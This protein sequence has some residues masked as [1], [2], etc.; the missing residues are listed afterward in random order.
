MVIPKCALYQLTTHYS[1]TIIEVSMSLLLFIQLQVI[2]YLIHQAV[3]YNSSAITQYFF[4]PLA[5]HA[6]QCLE[7]SAARR[8]P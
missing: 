2:E 6:Q 3:V 4:V 8:H 5:A 1:V 7:A